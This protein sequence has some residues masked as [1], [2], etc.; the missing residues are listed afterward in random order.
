[1]VIISSMSDPSYSSA[2]MSDPSYSSA[3]VCQSPSFRGAILF[4][5]VAFA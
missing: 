4:I 3:S 2:C 5:H 1:M